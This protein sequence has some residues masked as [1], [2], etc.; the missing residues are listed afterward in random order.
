VNAVIT[1]TTAGASDSTTT[2][3]TAAAAIVAGT[4]LIAMRG[5]VRPDSI[6]YWRRSTTSFCTASI[7][8]PSSTSIEAMMV[9]ICGLPPSSLTNSLYAFTASTGMR[10]PRIAGMPKLPITCVKTT[11]PAPK[12]DG[13]MS[14]SVTP[15]STRDSGCPRDRAASSRLRST[16]FRPTRIITKA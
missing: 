7:A 6:W 10:G 12:M 8:T 11:S 16:A 9:C 13:M 1:A 3:T 2:S 4:P 5:G 15:V 14:G